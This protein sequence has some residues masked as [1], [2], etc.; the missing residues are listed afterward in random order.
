MPRQAEL[1]KAGSD[2]L[3][4]L[5]EAETSQA[6]WKRPRPSELSRKDTLHPVELNAGCAVCF[7]FLVLEGVMHADVGF[8]DTAFSYSCSCN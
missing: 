7:R 6:V 1:P 3:K 5:G 8:N 2:Q 4:C